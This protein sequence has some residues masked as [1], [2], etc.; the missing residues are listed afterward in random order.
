M[1]NAKFRAAM[2][3]SAA[4]L[5]ELL[6]VNNVNFGK[7][8]LLVTRSL[9]PP[10]RIGN[11]E[12]SGRVPRNENAAC[13]FKVVPILGQGR[14]IFGTVRA[15]ML[16]ISLKRYPSIRR[17]GEAA[18]D[19]GEISPSCLSYFACRSWAIVALNIEGGPSSTDAVLAE[20]ATYYFGRR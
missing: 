20:A 14:F 18:A 7:S 17:G 8:K 16:I 15:E 2:I 11:V 5:T 10:P 4:E 12:Q 13:E 19:R 3:G 9:Q 1:L 6:P